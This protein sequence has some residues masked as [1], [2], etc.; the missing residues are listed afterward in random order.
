MSKI[1]KRAYLQYVFKGCVQSSRMHWRV[2]LLVVPVKNRFL[3][4]DGQYLIIG[5]LR[6]YAKD[7]E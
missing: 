1:H 7:Y 6:Q 3:F 4:H 2:L 5:Y